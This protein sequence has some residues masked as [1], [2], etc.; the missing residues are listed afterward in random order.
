MQL[1]H[2]LYLT[3]RAM[4]AC[5]GVRAIGH[6][7]CRT[8]NNFADMMRVHSCCRIM[9][10]VS[11]DTYKILSVCSRDVNVI[12][13]VM[14]VTRLKNSHHLRIWRSHASEVRNISKQLK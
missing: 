3:L 13:I 12:V 9:L 7:R 8:Q 2:Y 1:L 6:F 10:E 14:R 11:L 5:K 4:H